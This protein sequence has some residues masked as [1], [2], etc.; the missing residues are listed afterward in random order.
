MTKIMLPIWLS[1][2]ERVVIPV[3]RAHMDMG[4]YLRVLQCRNIFFFGVF[5]S[6]VN[7]STIYF[8]SKFHIST[9]ETMILMGATSI[10][11]LFAYVSC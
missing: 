10:L 2:G 7:E 5:Y 8:Q 3:A 9:F 11:I 6:K 4:P 1:R